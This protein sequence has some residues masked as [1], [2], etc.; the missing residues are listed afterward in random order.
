M[1][2]R[3]EILDEAK[4][5]VC[6]EREQQYGGPEDNFKLIARLWSEYIAALYSQGKN[7]GPAEV[8]DMMILLKVARNTTGAKLDNWIDICGY[9]ACGGEIQFGCIGA[10]DECAEKEVSDE[11]LRTMAKYILDICQNFDEIQCDTCECSKNYGCAAGT[12]YGTMMDN[13]KSI[14]DGAKKLVIAEYEQLTKK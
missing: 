3:P 12:V 10:F 8:A 9:A 13:P 6:G 2:T 5:I 7:L 4:K 14:E 11:Q 1:N